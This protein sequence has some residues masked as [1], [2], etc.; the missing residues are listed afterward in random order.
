TTLDVHT[1]AFASKVHDIENLGDD[2][3]RAAASVSNRLLDRPVAA[4]QSGGIGEASQVSK[5]LVSLRRQVEDLDPSRE[6]NLLS[7]HRLLGVLPFGDKVR[8]YF[9]KYQSSQKNLDTIIQALYRG[10]DQLRQDN[11]DIEQEKQNLWAIMGRLRQ[12]TYLGQQ[13]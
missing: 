2:D 3:I 12:Y 9:D 4:M 1:D 10:Q 7:P 6:G 13:L 11:A 5:S 8:D